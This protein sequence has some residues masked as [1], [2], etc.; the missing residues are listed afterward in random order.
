MDI[1]IDEKKLENQEFLIEQRGKYLD[2]IIQQ[3][4]VK[5]YNIFSNN[6]HIKII[7][8]E[9]IIL[10]KIFDQ[11]QIFKM[12]NNIMTEIRFFDTIEG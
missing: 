8:G 10:D 9:N 2:F 6:V 3:H 4:G 7:D 12:V 1:F 11:N 5:D